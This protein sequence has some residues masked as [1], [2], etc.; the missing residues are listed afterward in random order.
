MF[1]SARAASL[2][3][4]CSVKVQGGSLQVTVNMFVARKVKI[5]SLINTVFLNFL[6]VLSVSAEETIFNNKK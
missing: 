5:I 3:V 2:F 6:D 4:L 1:L